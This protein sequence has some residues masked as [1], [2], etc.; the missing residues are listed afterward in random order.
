[1]KITLYPQNFALVNI[2]LKFELKKGYNTIKINK[3]PE[4]TDE[5]SIILNFLNNDDISIKSYSFNPNSKDE[6]NQD[7]TK[8]LLLE[9]YSAEDYNKCEV[10]FSYKVLDIQFENFYNFLYLP[11]ENNILMDGWIKI[12]NHKLFNFENVDLQLV[13]NYKNQN[14]IFSI[15]GRYNINSPERTISFISLKIPVEKKLLARYDSDIVKECIF[16]TNSKENS[17]GSILMPGTTSVHF[18]DGEGHLHLLGQDNFSLYL[19]DEEI[20]FEIGDAEE[21]IK[22]ERK[23]DDNLFIN[24]FTNLTDQIV[25]LDAEFNTFGGKIMDSNSV[26]EVDE[27]H[28]GHLTMRLL[29]KGHNVVKYRIEPNEIEMPI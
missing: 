8:E 15:D 7:K 25:D 1:M 2:P 4:T 10:D 11:S 24:I 20:E 3:I 17:L 21:I 28:I 27:N 29:P 13:H 14:I 18:K 19:P 26:L 16:F 23:I 22:I 6:L 12:K 5:K 9:I